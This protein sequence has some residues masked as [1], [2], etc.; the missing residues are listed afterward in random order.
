M[1]FP[2]SNAFF[3]GEKSLDYA[4]SLRLGWKATV[5]VAYF[6]GLIP[7]NLSENCSHRSA[8]ICAQVALLSLRS[9]F[10]RKS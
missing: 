8:F 7:S 9:R 10:E 1:F 6:K 4:I 5:K 2:T 3:R